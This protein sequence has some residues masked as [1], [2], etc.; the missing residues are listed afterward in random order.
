MNHTPHP[1]HDHVHSSTC[2]HTRIRHVEHVDYLHDGHL[3]HE[4][5]GHVDE[6]IIEETA[7]NPARCTP[8]HACA[9]HATG[10]VHGANCGH[11]TVP[12]G[13][14]RDYLVDGHLHHPH[15]GHCDDHGAVQRS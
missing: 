11:E 7:D 10:H 5:G 2:G 15:G 9:G 13:D 1:D 8:S 6:C 12:H 4:H 14:H 3:H